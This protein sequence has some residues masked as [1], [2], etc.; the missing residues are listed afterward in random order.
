MLPCKHGASLVFL[1]FLDA[2]LQHVEYA[3]SGILNVK[4]TLWI[5]KPPLLNQTRL[6]P[7]ATVRNLIGDIHPSLRSK[8]LCLQGVSAVKYF[9]ETFDLDCSSFA[10]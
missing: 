3:P 1:G 7:M 8:S 2:S 4:G 9:S 5:G 10:S 6:F